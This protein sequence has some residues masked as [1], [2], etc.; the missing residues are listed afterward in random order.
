MSLTNSNSITSI[1]VSTLNNRKSGFREKMLQKIRE[2]YEKCNKRPEINIPT[3]TT[4]F[5]D[6]THHSLKEM[7]GKLIDIYGQVEVENKIEPTIL[8]EV[9]ASQTEPYQK[10]SQGS[11]GIYTEVAI[12]KK[13]PLIYILPEEYKHE[14]DLPLDNAKDLNNENKK[15]GLYVKHYYWPEILD[16]AKEYDYSGLADQIENFVEIP[17]KAGSD[18]L[19][20]KNESLFLQTPEYIFST[21]EKLKELNNC[22]ATVIKHPSIEKIVKTPYEISYSYNNDYWLGIKPNIDK[23]YLPF[24]AVSTNKEKI[25]EKVKNNCYTDGL[26]YYAPYTSKEAQAIDQTIS[27]QLSKKMGEK[28]LVEWL[29]NHKGFFNTLFSLFDKVFKMTKNYKRLTAESHSKYDNNGIGYFLDSGSMFFIGFNPSLELGEGKKLGKDY[30]YIFSWAIHKNAINES[31][32]S[33]KGLPDENN[34]YYFPL[35]SNSDLFLKFLSA[36]TANEQFDNFNI[37]AEKVLE[38]AKKYII[39]KYEHIVSGK[40]DE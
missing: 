14:K 24:L 25:D 13:I 19:L 26:F 31:L 3:D 1:L 36:E 29:E 8:I 33:L 6:G 35:N 28:K 38:D 15:K 16:I 2:D 20:S 22:I 21:F 40:Q 27:S 34:Y 30:Q 39:P 17:P 9:K 32:Y 7:K 18:I 37:L 4:I 5:Y 11:N 23:T 12:E 10:E